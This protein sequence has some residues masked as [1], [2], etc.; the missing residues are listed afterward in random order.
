MAK[1]SG[2]VGE[3]LTVLLAH[4]DSSSQ[5]D[6]W[7]LDF[8]GPYG[9]VSLGDSSKLPVE[10]KGN[11]KII[12]N[13]GREEYISDTYYIPGMKSN[14][15]S[16]GQLLQKGYVI[17][18]ENML[19]TLRNARRKLIARVQM[20]KNRMFPLK[21]NTKIGSCNIG[22]MEDES[23]KW[24]LRFGHL[25]F[26]GLKLL[27]SGEMVRGLPQIEA[28]HQVCEGCVFGKQARLSF[29][30]GDTWR[31][32]APLQLV[33]T[34]ICGPLDPMS[35]GGN[36]YFITFIDDFSRKT[37]VYFLK[38]KSTAL[39]VFKEFKA[40]TEA[41]S[42]HKLVA[43]RSDR[44][45]EYTS[46][47]FKAYCKEQGIRHQLTADYTPQQNGI[48]KRKNRTI[49][50]MT[51]MTPQEAWSGYK[52]NVAHLRV[53]GC[54]AYAQVPKAKRRKLD[55]RGEQCVFVG[56][57]EESKAYKLYNPLIGKLVVSRDVIFSEEDAWKW[58]NKEVNKGKIVSTD[59]EEPEVIPLVEQQP[60]QSIT[61]TP[62]HRIARSGPTSNEERSSS[63][64]V[65]LRNHEPLSFNEAV[66]E[67]R[68]RI[69][70]EEEIHAIEKNDTWELIKL[71][72]NQKAIGVKWVYK[73]KHT[74]N[75]NV[76]RFKSRL[77]A[78]GYK[79]K[80]G[81]DY[82]EVYAP[83]AR[84]DTALYGLKQAPR[85]WNSRIDN[86]LHQN[87][88]QKCPYEHSVYMKNDDLL[89]TGNNEAMFREFKQS[90]FSEFEMTDNGLMSY[91]LGIEVKQESDGIYIS[92]QKYM[93]DILEKF[94]MDKCNDVNTPVAI[95][96]KLSKEGEGEFVN[97]T[98]YKSLVRSL[99]YLTITRPNIVYG[100]GL[101]SWYMETPKESHWLAA[102]RILRYIR[103]TLNYGLFYNFG[104]DAKL[105]GYSDSD[106][107]GDQDERKSTTGYVFFL[108]STV[109][110]WTSKKQS[111]IA[112]S[113]CEAEYIVAAS[114]VCEAIWLRNMLK[115]LCHPQMESTVIHVDNMSA[116][117]LA[118]NPVQ[119]GRSKHIDTRFHFFRDHVKQ[120]TIELV[121]CHT[122]E[123][124][125][126][127][128]TKPLPI[129]SFQL[130]HDM[131]G[132]KAF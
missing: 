120:K 125:V 42:N 64:P 40:L 112:L 104:E 57:S 79:Q 70:M 47:A 15:L 114:T 84:L 126:D 99:R 25:H 110:S 19:L 80:Y 58:K 91:F 51:R 131:L 124:V 96:L 107:G 3:E 86:Y 60:A 10:G 87:G 69:A 132:M 45:G 11:I 95:G 83:V 108:G 29:P 30:V 123:Q 111:I 27:S 77:V 2:N 72:P 98:M 63:T 12:Q 32:K 101:M 67:D 89:F 20:S 105:F 26:N 7:Y 53:F 128:F 127:I 119:H 14:I 39:K 35:Y 9:S 43:M 16:I 52:P 59:L 121:Y 18:M 37:W 88:F 100:I 23:W 94:N 65:R 13:D 22:V 48:A 6:V 103:G 71:P 34:D 130:L 90:M 55:D 5:Q 41:E 54:V 68:W 116:N 73:I 46:N 61:T 117:K 118:K 44:G 4:H 113:S 76:D 75:G 81:V 115:S 31:A 106:W 49:L 24:H 74:A 109:F 56:Y 62:L 97:S 129:E 93:R 33:H 102:K 17:H 122:K 66:E 92:Q 82:D 21:L 38:E 8:D 28:T 1:S 85:A 78:K 50:D 36:R